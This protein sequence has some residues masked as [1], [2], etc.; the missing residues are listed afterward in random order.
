MKKPEYIWYKDTGIA[1]CVI[2]YKDLEF[3][4]AAYCHPDDEDVKSSLTGQTIAEH[5]A[6][7]DYLRYVRDFELQPQ[8]KA[9]YQLYYSMKH[10]KHYNKKSYEAKML[11]RQI[12]LLE[13]D[14]KSVKE[15]I[16]DQKTELRNYL[17][18]KES[19]HETIRL[20]K[21]R[22]AELAENNQNSSEES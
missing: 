18:K 14:L 22:K 21:K 8:L 4:G 16:A 7:I 9:L 20:F 17:N 3:Y 5:R 11:Y 12:N 6:L 19:A 1:H 10:S 13:K 15:A 2:K